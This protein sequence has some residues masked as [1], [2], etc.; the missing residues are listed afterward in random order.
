M[1]CSFPRNSKVQERISIKIC[2]LYGGASRTHVLQK[3]ENVSFLMSRDVDSRR[4]GAGGSNTTQRKKTQKEVENDVISSMRTLINMGPKGRLIDLMKQLISEVETMDS[5]QAVRVSQESGRGSSFRK[6]KGGPSHKPRRQVFE[7]TP[8]YEKRKPDVSTKGKGGIV[9]KTSGPKRRPDST[10]GQKPVIPKTESRT[11]ARRPPGSEKPSLW[12]VKPKDWGY[13]VVHNTTLELAEALDNGQGPHFA[14]AH[15]AN[16]FVEMLQLMKGSPDSRATI[17]FAGTLSETAEAEISHFKNSKKNMPG[18]IGGHLRVQPV[19]VCEWGEAPLKLKDVCKIETTKKPTVTDPNKDTT[20]VRVYMAK[21][22]VSETTWANTTQNPGRALRDWIARLDHKHLKLVRDLWGWEQFEQ[23]SLRGRIR[24][25]TDLAKL[26]ISQS[27]NTAG[28][29]TWFFEPADWNAL[30]IARPVSLWIPLSDL[31]H[32]DFLQTA[33]AQGGSLGLALGSKQVAARVAADDSGVTPSNCSWKLDQVPRSFAYDDV[34]EVLLATGFTDVEVTAK[35]PRKAGL[36]AW[37]FRAL[38]K[39]RRDQ[40]PICLG[41][42]S[43]EEAVFLTAAREFR[44]KSSKAPVPLRQE[45]GTSFVSSE[46]RP[47]ARPSPS[48]APVILQEVEV[49]SP[50]ASNEPGEDSEMQTDPAKGAKRVPAKNTGASPE[51]KRSK[52]VTEILEHRSSPTPAKAT[53]YSMLS[54]VQMDTF[55][56]RTVLTDSCERP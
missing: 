39:D 16:V 23:G 17:V 6:G 4:G 20:V 35:S 22:F 44:K 40:V 33:R 11:P 2:L 27:G 12:N 45:K 15:D 53:A 46:S 29:T 18:Y 21:R 8:V 5:E 32:A 34:R 31:E 7:S 52:A 48:T 28:A 25:T 24:V 14:Q 41:D 54:Q 49:K 3:T 19:H 1:K 43:D 13:E 37:F 56:E 38:R 10:T 42:I 30:N 36:N 47:L 26:L 51:S 50:K 9:S 55:K